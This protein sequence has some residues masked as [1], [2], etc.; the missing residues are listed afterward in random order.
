MDSHVRPPLSVYCK[1]FRHFQA[2][3][4]DATAIPDGDDLAFWENAKRV[5]SQSCDRLYAAK[6]DGPPLRHV[7]L[8]ALAPIPLLVYLGS[9]LSTGGNVQLGEDMREMGLHGPGRHI[10]PLADLGIG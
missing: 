9:E 6:M 5:V 4:E 10:K 2:S 7:S 1:G 3:S 8:F